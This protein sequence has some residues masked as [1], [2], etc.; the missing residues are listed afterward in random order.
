MAA[1]RTADRQQ[2]GSTSRRFAGLD[3]AA[4]RLA[5]RSEAEDEGPQAPKQSL[6]ARFSIKNLA[7]VEHLA[8]VQYSI[9]VRKNAVTRSHARE[10]M[11]RRIE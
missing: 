9:V 1:I 2:D 3:V 7:A 5:V 4:Q 8:L 6:R 11:D 10:D